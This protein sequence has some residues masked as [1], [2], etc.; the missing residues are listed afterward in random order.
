VPNMLGVLCLLLSNLAW[1]PFQQFDL[2]GGAA[3]SMPNCSFCFRQLL[4]LPEARAGA[5]AAQVVMRMV[6][7]QDG[8]AE[9][10]EPSQRTCSSVKW[11]SAGFKCEGSALCAGCLMQLC[12]CCC[13]GS[14]SVPK[15]GT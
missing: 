14:L 5:A 1:V 3:C 7:R 8:F 10:L 6:K 4:I 2:H 11:S 9:P 13:C 12:C 15:R